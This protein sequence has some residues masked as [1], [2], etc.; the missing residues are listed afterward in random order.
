MDALEEVED[1]IEGARLLL[2]QLRLGRSAGVIGR[3]A[4]NVQ[5]AA[6]QDELLRAIRRRREL[7]AVHDLAA[8]QE[9]AR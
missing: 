6:L 8:A 1:R 3:R 5:A 7:L 4:Y 2:D 9:G